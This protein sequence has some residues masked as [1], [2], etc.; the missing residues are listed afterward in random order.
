MLKQVLVFIFC[1]IAGVA[2]AEYNYP[3]AYW[4]IWP[5]NGGTVKSHIVARKRHVDFTA[6]SNSVMLYTRANLKGASL[7]AMQFDVKVSELKQQ[8][9]AQGKISVRFQQST[10]KRKDCGMTNFAWQPESGRYSY[11]FI[12]PAKADSAMIGLPQLTGIEGKFTITDC[13]I[14][15]LPIAVQAVRFAA[16]PSEADWAKAPAMNGFFLNG[17]DIPATA[18]SELKI[19]YDDSN[20]YVRVICHEQNPEKL[21]KAATAFD[22]A[23][24]RDDSVELFLASGDKAYQFMLN[25]IG[26]RA[27]GELKQPFPGEPLKFHGSWNGNWSGKGTIGKKSWTADFAIP[28]ATLGVKPEAG[29]ILKLNAMR[30][31]RSGQNESSQLDRRFGIPSAVKYFSELRFGDKSAELHRSCEDMNKEPLRVERK[32]NK[33]AEFPRRDGK[34][35]VVQAGCGF[36]LEGYSRGFQLKNKADWLNRQ[37]TFLDNMMSASMN[38][39]AY[40]PWV[41]DRMGGKQKFSEICSRYPELRFSLAVHNSSHDRSV[42]ADGTA[43]FYSGRFSNLADAAL[44]KRINDWLENYLTSRPDIVKYLLYARGYDEP[45]NSL[46]ACFS[47]STNEKCRPALQ[48]LDAEIRNSTGYGRFGLCDLNATNND[49]DAPFRNIAFMRWWNQEAVKPLQKQREILRRLAP[50]VAFMPITSNNC[51]AYSGVELLPDFGACGDWLGVDPYPSATMSL[52]SRERALYHTGFATRLAYDLAAPAKIYTYIQAFRYHGYNPT[53]NDLREWTSQ[54][55]KNGA[56]IIAWYGLKNLEDCPA[57]YPE[58]L[59][60]SKIITGMKPLALPEKSPAAILFN[61]VGEWGQF[62]FAQ[63]DYYNLYV[64]LGEKLKS[65]FAFISDRQI[66]K[67]G[68]IPE[69]IRLCI[70]PSLEYVTPETAN[71]LERFVRRGGTLVI[72]DPDAFRAAPDATVLPQRKIFAGADLQNRRKDNSL[73]WN[74]RKMTMFTNSPE[75]YVCNVPEGGKVEMTYADNIPAASRTKLGKGQ[76]IFFA[77]RPFVINNGITDDVSWSNY[78]GSLLREHKIRTNLP[79]W[80]FLLP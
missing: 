53:V 15:E 61:Y 66:D 16:M 65:D 75:A 22:G 21:K 29:N 49:P 50:G 59:R 43:N 18:E 19:G 1:V 57:V 62:K 45:T 31:S 37:L 13:Q 56:D 12:T 2:M 46:K 14:K 73:R 70:A 4:G 39:P 40:F 5:R 78:F 58:T 27:D 47:I 42:I 71:A 6:T 20:L 28:F 36:E 79:H 3:K 10:A 32:K 44:G 67:Q 80:D 74:G 33:R 52:I 17:S 30:N 54:A 9:N 23:V 51:S 55:L 24:Y 25:A 35:L 48:K 7:Y 68:D 64:I 8:P 34:Y 63:M 76:V 72:L 60:L 38:C 26:T 41:E 69:Y 77:S 11:S